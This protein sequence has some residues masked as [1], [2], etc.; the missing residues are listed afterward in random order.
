AYIY[1]AQPDLY[2]FP[3]RRSSDL[4]Y[5]RL[6][7][8]ANRCQNVFQQRIP[9]IVLYYSTRQPIIRLQEIGSLDKYRAT[10]RR[11]TGD[12][13]IKDRLTKEISDD[14]VRWLGVC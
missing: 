8:L 4:K 3:T 7:A 13:S 12:I 6:A 5:Q 1:R 10:I 9:L 14:V 2:S 11:D